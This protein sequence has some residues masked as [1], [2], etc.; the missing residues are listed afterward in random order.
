MTA[1]RFDARPGARV[2]LRLRTVPFAALRALLGA[3]LLAASLPA[4]A[5]D[6]DAER[7]AELLHL[8][9]HDCGSC[10]GMSLKGGLGPALTPEVLAQRPKDAMVDTILQGRPGTPMPPW[11]SMLTREEAQWLTERLYRGETDGQ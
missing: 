6:P 9:R 1:D 11:S 2:A 3:V 7:Q 10:H 8:L 5:L 4:A